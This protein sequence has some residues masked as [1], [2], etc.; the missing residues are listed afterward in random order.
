MEV[1]ALSVV[2][3]IPTV[4]VE[5]SVEPT[6]RVVTCRRACVGLLRR[7]VPL[8]VKKSVSETLGMGGGYAP[9][10]NSPLVLLLSVGLGVGLVLLGMGCAA[11][12]PPAPLETAACAEGLPQDQWPGA[13]VADEALSLVLRS[14]AQPVRVEYR[15]TIEDPALVSARRVRIAFF[16]DDGSALR[17]RLL[18]PMGMAIADYVRADGRWELTIPSLSVAEAGAVGDA[19]PRLMGRELPLSPDRLS[20]LFAPAAVGDTVAWQAGA[21]AVLEE[22]ATSGEVVRTLAFDRVDGA[23][24]VARETLFEDGEA[25]MVADHFE[26]RLVGSGLLWS[27]RSEIQDARRGSQLELVTTGI[28]TDGVTDALFVLRGDDASPTSRASE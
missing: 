1:V 16:R 26:H 14:R 25:R 2:A 7:F 4:E 22:R 20:A 28:R 8:V 27:H 17:M 18:D 12:T 6:R 9:P 19:V 15:A 3:G 10:T 23:W 24:V 5:L 11:K 21:C 13:G